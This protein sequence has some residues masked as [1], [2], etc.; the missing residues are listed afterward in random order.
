MT[1]TKKTTLIAERGSGTGPRVVHKGN[2]GIWLN[3][4]PQRSG[5][6]KSGNMQHIRGVTGRRAT[7][8]GKIGT[9]DI[10]DCLCKVDRLGARLER[11]KIA[12]INPNGV[13][14]FLL[15]AQG[16]LHGGFEYGGLNVRVHPP[17]IERLGEKEAVEAARQWADQWML[18]LPTPRDVVRCERVSRI[19]YAVDIIVEKGGPDDYG[20]AV[21]EQLISRLQHPQAFW[22]TGWEIGR[23]GADKNRLERVIVSYDKFQERWDNKQYGGLQEYVTSLNNPSLVVHPDGCVTEGDGNK[24]MRV[25]RIEFRFHRSF[26]KG[27]EISDADEAIAAMPALVAVASQTTRLQQRCATGNVFPTNRETEIW[28]LVRNTVM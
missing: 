22:V 25:W 19:D 15:S 8:T 10:G 3:Y 20:P 16:R 24:A 26:L 6:V 27:K 18:Q 28:N 14:L 21:H 11:F 4:N 2:D 9:W 23:G 1:V 17:L 7:Q 12:V 13:Q 5:G